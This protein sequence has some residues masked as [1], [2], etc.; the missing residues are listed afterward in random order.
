[1]RRRHTARPA[2]SASR[3]DPCP[4]ALDAGFSPGARRWSTASARLHAVGAVPEVA[5][6]LVGV[7]C[8]TRMIDRRAAG[9][10]R[11]G[12]ARGRSCEHLVGVGA[13]RRAEYA[14][15]AGSVQRRDLSGAASA[16][17]PRAPRRPRRASPPGRCTAGRGG[18]SRRRG[19]GRTATTS[20]RSTDGP[21]HRSIGRPVS[22]RTDADS[23]CGADLRDV[24]AEADRRHRVV[25]LAEQVD[26]RRDLG[27]HGGG[28][29]ACRRGSAPRRSD[30][31]ASPA[32]ASA[33]RT[34]GAG[35]PGSAGASRS[36]A[37]CRTAASPGSPAGS[38]ASGRRRPSPAVPRHRAP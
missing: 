1:M 2:S 13:A 11:A 27:L 12:S 36:R 23:R 22:A 4:R 34:C 8:R 25:G 29:L 9:A 21:P 38:P 3:P 17:R 32:P 15:C 26:V 24:R 18:R 7:A 35:S 31:A 16:P 6:D 30:R 33:R 28:H 5:G 10:P 20:S 14:S 37:R 19:R